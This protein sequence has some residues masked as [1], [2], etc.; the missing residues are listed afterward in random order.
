MA[1]RGGAVGLQRRGAWLR[2]LVGACAAR[3][4]GHV[5]VLLLARG[6]ASRGGLL[7]ATV[8]M[9]RGVQ[10]PVVSVLVAVVAVAR[11]SRMG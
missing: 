5:L 2:C 11:A 4:M 1:W 6:S 7:R 9:L 8:V 10:I 3:L